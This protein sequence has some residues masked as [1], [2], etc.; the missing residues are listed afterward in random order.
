M[1]FLIKLNKLFKVIHIVCC[2]VD[3]YLN[4]PTFKIVGVANTTNIPIGW[5]G[6][7]GGEPRSGRKMLRI[8]LH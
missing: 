3:G 6:G 7:L 5:E 8:R 4:F 1:K 2:I